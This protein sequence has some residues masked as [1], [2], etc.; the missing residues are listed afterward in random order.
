MITSHPAFQPDP[1]RSAQEAGFDK[2]IE[3]L[4]REHAG[5]LAG[6]LVRLGADPALVDDIVQDS[7]LAVRRRWVD[8]RAYDQPR[9]YLFKVA[10]NRMRRLHRDRYIRTE[11]HADPTEVSR[12]ARSE[13]GLD[14]SSPVNDAI[15]Q[16]PRRQRET[17]LLRRIYG[18][19]CRETAE[20]LQ[21]GE[22]SVKNYLSLGKQRLMEILKREGE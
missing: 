1:D 6:Y 16:L 7:F 20:I 12:R 22:G 11:P 15:G 4:F 3:T 8:V 14:E 18:F 19:S 10:T 9:A 5:R 21:I 2:E 17:V 13:A